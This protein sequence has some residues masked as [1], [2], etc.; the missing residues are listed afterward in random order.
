MDT[1]NQSITYWHAAQL[2]LQIEQFGQGYNEPIKDK[3]KKRNPI[4]IEDCGLNDDNHIEIIY[5]DL[6]RQ[7]SDDANWINCR[8]MRSELE[9]YI[10]ENK[11]NVCQFDDVQGY[12]KEVVIKAGYIAEAETERMARAYI[13]DGYPI[14]LV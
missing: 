8:I 14:I 10:H 3:M 5:C 13:E 2:A 1:S 6:G 12:S 4:F 11:L 7:N 9:A